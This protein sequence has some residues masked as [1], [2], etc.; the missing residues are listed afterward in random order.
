VVHVHLRGLT[1]RP[2][3]RRLLPGGAWRLA[4]PV[5]YGLLIA[6][7][8]IPTACFLL[9]AFF[10]GAFGQGT[11][12]FSLAPFRS[13]YQGYV[14]TALT[15]SL[16]VGL[17]ASAVALAAAVALAW[18]CERIRIP[19]AG[20]WRL[21]VWAL[22]LV[23]TYLSA[24]GYEDLLA[25][26][27]VIAQVTGWNP[28][29]LDHLLLGPAGV[30]LVLSLRGI[31]FA[32]FAVAGVIR[33]LGTGPA[34]AARVHGLS[35]WRTW[36]VQLGTLTPALLAGFVLV[37]AETV[38]DFGVASTLAADAHFTVITYVI[39][40]FTDAIPINFPAAAAVSWSLIAVF[41]VVVLAQ[42]RITG[43]R[44]FSGSAAPA[45]P[46]AG[47]AGRRRAA[48]L[49]SGVFFVI[50]LIGPVLGILV[51]SVLGG[52]A[53]SGY[54]VVATNST[55]FTFAAYK[56][57]FTNAGMLSPV[58]LSL[59]LGLAGATV[60]I[61]V[62]L[63][64]NLWN[65][66]R[67][68]GRT[69][70]LTDV[71][72][73]AVI[74][75]PSIVLAAGFVFFYNL[76]AVYN[77]IPIYDTQWLLLV[78]YIVGFAPIAVRMLS[79]PMAQAGRSG[80]DAGRVHGSNAVR[81]WAKGV[82]PLIWRPL[83]MVWLFLVAIIMFEL[84]LSEILHAPSGEPLA[85]SVAVQYKSLVAIGTAL[86]VVGIVVMIAVLAVVGGLLWL[87]GA[88]QRRL[89]ARQEA[90]VDTLIGQLTPTGVPPHPTKGHAS[91]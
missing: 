10:P 72:L 69:A 39:F 18:L 61:A 83:V 22:L 28:A 50:A 74:G 64:I 43:G 46:T 9:L 84:P 24:L 57:L 32:Y 88:L 59:E 12:G 30:T 26:Q 49:V 52:T 53:N 86:T 71:G 77:T 25:P 41:A 63:V 11:G 1:R 13:A 80:Y 82:L 66:H 51:S 45:A 90:A 67:G 40:A 17:A 87:A 27:G 58:W 15:N 34:D 44:D 65:Q 35:R 29:A 75:L 73:V 68:Q 6:L 31:A 60:A 55:G 79:G 21:G 3:R 4:A 48:A 47:P 33:S 38:S 78:G 81:A 2:A 16:W 76:P 91:P 7:L 8:L 19:G 70:T 42:R 56:A 85:V 54:G 20:A 62:G 5:P 89:R 14:V 37:F 23:P 36:L